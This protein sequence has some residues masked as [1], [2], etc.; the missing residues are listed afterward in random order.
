M[1][2]GQREKPV[3]R[4]GKEIN[5]YIYILES[6]FSSL[7]NISSKEVEIVLV[8]VHLVMRWEV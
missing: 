6:I 4:I 1:K 2:K 8:H 3:T 7:C 5:I